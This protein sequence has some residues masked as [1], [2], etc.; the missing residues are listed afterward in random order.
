MPRDTKA[1]L[2]R[3]VSR[4]DGEIPT[5][6]WADIVVKW[7]RGNGLEGEYPTSLGRTA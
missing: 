3:K 4:L 5:G 6:D 7:F 1:N 2:C